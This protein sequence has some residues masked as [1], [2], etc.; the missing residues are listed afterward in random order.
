MFILPAQESL[1]RVLDLLVEL[2]IR[3]GAD[4][5]ATGSKYDFLEMTV[6]LPAL[7]LQTGWVTSLCSRALRSAYWLN[8]SELVTFQLAVFPN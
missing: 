3:G 6:R 2:L 5:N 1:H 7:T 8:T 4:P